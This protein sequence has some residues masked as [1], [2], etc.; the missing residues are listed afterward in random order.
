M[1]E[2]TW[3]EARLIPTS[4]ISGADEQERRAT[5]ALLAVMSSVKEFGRAI[6]VPLGA[7][8][9]T[10]KTFIEVPFLLADKRCYPDGL[11]RVS[12]GSRSWTCLVEVKTGTNLLEATQLEN[13]L[14]I[15]R[16][17]GFDALLT[18]SNEIPPAA[19]QHPTKVDRRKLK[20]V[21]LHH[22]SWSQVLA[23]AVIQKEH[24]GIADPDQAWILG[25]L[26][27]YLEHPRSGALEFDDMGASWVPVRDA[28]AAGT[29]RVNDKGAPEVAARFDA[30]LRY[31]S[32]RLGRQL[33]TEVTPL[34]SRKEQAD[35]SLRSQALVSSLVGNGTLAAAIRI[36]NT[37]G[38]LNVTLDLRAG[39]VSCHVDLDAPKDGRPAT[40]VN[41]VVRQLKTAPDS[42][43]V[44]AYQAFSRGG[45]TAEL[46]RDVRANPALLLADAK[47]EIKAFRLA[48]TR[49]L[50]PK[51]G[52]GRGGAIDSVLDAVGAFYAE[53]LSQLKAWTAAPPKLREESVIEPLPPID[54]ALVSTSL[55]SQDTPEPA[56]AA[57][58]SPQGGPEIIA[59][60]E[61]DS[62]EAH[63]EDHDEVPA[64]WRAERASADILASDEPASSPE[65]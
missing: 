16:E 12:R 34:L 3:H 9:G 30:L 4:G 36:P 47:N 20:K 6:T 28:V 42:V 54:E 40:R 13:Y 37:V 25:E 63:E 51:R 1:S 15:A 27:R 50:G 43:R 23:E 33:G 49:P 48:L 41:W 65:E 38:P 11:I 32:L 18:I 57:A 26:I 17:Q 64:A 60:S 35:P 31:V 45:S 62:D 53:V 44:E 19:G 22:L 56:T 5:S 21:A 10:V 55:S 24:R 8:S 61:T 39:R 59:P 2:E 14:D 58:T 29:L 46:L 52:R 7:G